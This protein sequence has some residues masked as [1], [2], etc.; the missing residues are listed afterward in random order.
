ML[1]ASLLVLQAH[2]EPA[3][4]IV[5]P[6]NIHRRIHS[7]NPELITARLRVA[8]ACGRLA[9]AGKPA[10]PELE[11]GLEHN[12]RFREGR[13]EIG[14]SQRFPVTDRLRLEKQL[15][16][17]ELKAAEAEV[18][19]VERQL[20]AQARSLLVRI[21]A[22]R[23]GR[24]LLRE[25]AALAKAFAASLS[26]SASKGEGSPVEAGQARVEAASLAAAIRQLDAGE[27][28]LVG[29]LKPLLGM[30]AGEPLQ[31]GGTL[32]APALPAAA[33]DP[34]RRPDYQ[35]AAWTA[36]A[37]STAVSLE[38]ARRYDDV[39]GGLFA[40]AE[41]SEDLPRGFENEAILG[42]RFKIPLPLRNRNEGAIQEAEARKLRLEQQVDALGRSIRLEAETARAEMNEWL[43]LFNEI[44][45]T[46]LPLAAE[47]ADR[48]ESAR[49][50][51]Q[52]DLQ[53]VLRAREKHL[54]LSSAR[55]DALR[56][57]HLAR[58]RFEAAMGGQ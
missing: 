34:S 21:L 51:G 53:D 14:I 20:V 29:E 38:Q 54:Q 39:E 43:R 27:V 15:S 17:A 57:F 6:T 3:A 46:L 8:E 16:T 35:A 45:E 49:L 31:V 13:L 11:I 4:L 19:E 55:L 9:Q 10:N 36:Q 25:Q 56:E 18:R 30:R 47:Q 50:G 58:I 2:A 28:A 44:G 24:E 32:A 1:M 23:Q 40:A 5:S 41:R 22:G 37:A 7:Q 26:E 12:A 33:D 48:A 52:G 42:L